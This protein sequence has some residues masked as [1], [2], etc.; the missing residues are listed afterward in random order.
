MKSPITWLPVLMVFGFA[1]A[2]AAQTPV[3]TPT[4]IGVDH[5]IPVA[6]VIAQTNLQTG[7]QIPPAGVASQS[8][9]ASASQTSVPSP[10]AAEATPLSMPAMVGPLSAASPTTSDAGPLGKL[11]IN[12]V[13]SGFG[14]W[15]SNPAQG[16]ATASADISNGQIFIQKASGLWQ[17]YLQAGAYN[18]PI[19]GSPYISTGRTVNDYYGALPQYYLKLAPKGSFSFLVGQLPTLIGA[20]YTFTFENANIER[21]LLWNQEN[22]INRGVQVNYSK[23]KLGASLSWN[24]G[25]YSDRYNWLSGALTYTPSA[26]NSLEFVAGGNLGSTSYTNAATPLYQNNSDIYDLI[27]THTAKRWTLQ[28]YLQYTYVPVNAHI[29]VERATS[30]KGVALL[31]TYSLP[32]NL[33]VAGR[34]EYIAT[35]GNSSNGAVN[36]LYGP[37]SKALSVTVTPTYQ[38]KAFFTRAEFS[39]GHA[40]DLTPGDAFGAHGMNSSQA[41]GMVESGFMF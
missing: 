17:F 41:R 31:G 8:D 10:A 28:P 18:I 1:A 19:V 12:G 20:E 25:F 34:V 2:L 26:S 40:N 13:L 38:R 30:T 27:Y 5:D 37:G 35:T 4:E 7:Q 33:F 29:G 6:A 14:V 21:G 23:G 11:S 15:Q 22:A 3:A 32:H 36:L 9:G 24:D 39:F 16:D